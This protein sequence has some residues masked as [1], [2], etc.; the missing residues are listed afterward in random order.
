ML[1]A[2][3]RI[4]CPSG[5]CVSM[6]RNHYHD[7][8]DGQP[9]F[10]QLV[11]KTFE[12]CEFLTDVLKVERVEGHFPHRV[13]IHQSCHGLRELG[14]GRPSEAV[15]PDDPTPVSTETVLR[16]VSELEL[17]LPEPPDECCG[18]GGL[19]SVQFPELSSRIGLSRLQ[20]L[21]ATGASHVTSTD[22]SCLLHL[23]GLRR[24]ARFGPR[25][26]HLAEIL[27]RRAES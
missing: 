26:I 4:V 13:G 23:D 18:F 19:F 1:P 15:R 22:L 16:A 14:L 7:Y 8:L 3:Y 24:R 25:P 27:A 9:G 11:E 21:A 17:V 10:E 5:S 20:A 6:V 2:S 12:L